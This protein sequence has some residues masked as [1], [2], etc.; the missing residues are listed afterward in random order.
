METNPFP[1]GIGNDI[2]S[3]NFVQYPWKYHL[4]QARTAA[5]AIGFGLLSMPGPVG[6]GAEVGATPRMPDHLNAP[7]VHSNSRRG[8]ESATEHPAE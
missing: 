3:I 5:I 4:M 1:Y 2:V 7:S 8:A 6:I